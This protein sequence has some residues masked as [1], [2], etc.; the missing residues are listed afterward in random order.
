MK[1]VINIYVAVSTC[2]CFAWVKKA[3]YFGHIDVLIF[4]KLV[5]WVS[6]TLFNSITSF[7]EIDSIL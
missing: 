2:E 5:A 3:T 6:L 7:S 1:K 4:P